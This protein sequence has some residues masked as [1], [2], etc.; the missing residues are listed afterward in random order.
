MEP[1][2]VVDQVSKSFGRLKAVA[3]VSFSV[4]PGEIYG[5]AGPNGA[6]KTTLFN[7][8]SAIP[9]HADSGRILFK[10]QPIQ[11]IAAHK[12]N[13][14]GLARTFQRETVFETLSALENVLV[15]AAFGRSKNTAGPRQRALDMLDFV[16]LADRRHQEARHLALFEKKR[17]MLASALVTGPEL[18]LLDEPAA[19]LNQAEIGQS[20][21]LFRTINGQG[22]T[23][24][25]IEHILP[26][27][28]TL[29][30]RVM[31]LDHG[32]KL[33]EDLPD[34][35]VENQVVIEAYLGGC[36]RGR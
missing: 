19:G 34:H 23:I 22:V 32:Q 2:L 18:L 5:I 6:G 31:I 35:V 3:E 8:I 36:R 1:L 25:L 27:L 15:A 17:L 30:H 26:L 9:F 16:G 12:V 33:C 21:E 28:L 11:S 29:S 10:G 24:I 13:H 7:I 14:R 20:L 4:A